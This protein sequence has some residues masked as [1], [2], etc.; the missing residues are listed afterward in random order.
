MYLLDTNVVSEGRKLGTSRVDPVAAIW[1][2]GIDAEQTF[3]SAMTIFEL[4]RGV[5]QLERRDRVQGLML[6]RWLVDQVMTTFEH[7]ILPLSGEVALVCAGL[8]IPDPKSERDAW[9]AATAINAGLTLATRNVGD[10]AGMGVKLVN[11]FERED[12]D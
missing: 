11:P 4:E 12:E 6:R 8:H 5:Q 10:F 7:R 3:L 9:I 1:L 2:D